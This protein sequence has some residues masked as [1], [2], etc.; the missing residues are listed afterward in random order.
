MERFAGVVFLFFFFS[1]DVR[2]LIYT[3]NNPLAVLFLTPL[4][5]S[6]YCSVSIGFGVWAGV[7]FFHARYL[8]ES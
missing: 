7:E 4:R 5:F 8:N 3:S 6:R 2:L 1:T